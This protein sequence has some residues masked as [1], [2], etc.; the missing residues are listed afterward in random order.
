MIEHAGHFH[1]DFAENIEKLTVENTA[2]RKVHRTFRYSQVVLMCLDPSED[3]PWETHT[4]LDQFF[5]VEKGYGTV[6]IKQE[7]GEVETTY[8]GDGSWFTVEAGQPHRVT[9]FRDD[10]SLHLYAVYC[11]KPEHPKG[12]FQKRQGDAPMYLCE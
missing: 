11:G 10:K 12:T 8:V 2:Y 9:N 3:I 7:S 4:D 5:R 1:L 6:Q